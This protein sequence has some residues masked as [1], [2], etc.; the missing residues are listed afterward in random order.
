MTGTVLSA[1]L[2]LSH[3]I[4]TKPYEVDSFYKCALSINK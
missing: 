1:L 4:L 2:M 3:V